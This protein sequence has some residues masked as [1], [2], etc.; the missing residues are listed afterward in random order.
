M[1][2]TITWDDWLDAGVV[3]GVGDE[4]T[5][6]V[7]ERVDLMLAWVHDDS[8]FT[9]DP[10]VTVCDVLCVAA[11]LL[12]SIGEWDR[13]LQ[14]AEDAAAAGDAEV[15]GAHP[16]I[17]SILLSAERVD[18]ALDRAREILVAFRDDPNDVEPQIFERVGEAF[19]FADTLGD[20][21]TSTMAE[22]LFTIGARHVTTDDD[23][24]QWGMLLS[25][26]YR[27]RRAQGKPIDVQDAETEELRRE[28]GWEPL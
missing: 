10:E 8:A 21:R 17:I 3:A 24:R 25:G 6:F 5:T 27:V 26:R 9:L 23:G 1:P 19:E 16:T 13:A 22:R 7:Q 2:R 20:A 14:I 12:E 18:D 15:L 11:E 4:R 28:L